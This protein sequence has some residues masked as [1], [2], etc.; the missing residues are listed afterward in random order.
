MGFESS[1]A[2]RRRFAV[3]AMSNERVQE[4]LAPSSFPGFEPPAMPAQLA[5]MPLLTAEQ[6]KVA[7]AS[8]LDVLAHD[9]FAT[10]GAGGALL[11]AFAAQA[12]A[13]SLVMEAATRAPG[14]ISLPADVLGAVQAALRMPTNT[15]GMPELAWHV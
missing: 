3:L 14:S 7:V 10:P 8:E 6:E 1:D 13:L 2:A 15:G 5:D 9:I 4:A 11:V 12:R